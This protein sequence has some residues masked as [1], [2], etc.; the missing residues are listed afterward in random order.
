[1]AAKAR[2]IFDC[3]GRDRVPQLTLIIGLPTEAQETVKFVCKDDAPDRS[4]ASCPR[5]PKHNRD[6]SRNETTSAATASTTRALST[7]AWPRRTWLRKALPTSKPS[8]RLRSGW[9]QSA[10][11]AMSGRERPRSAAEQHAP[12]F[13][14][15]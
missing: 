14:I 13:P 7:K 3:G 12:K 6:Q 9:R 10:S 15:E 1:M 5:S 11:S 8:L 4:T 2:F